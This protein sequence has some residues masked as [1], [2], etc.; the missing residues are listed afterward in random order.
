MHHFAV[1]LDVTRVGDAVVDPECW[2]RLGVGQIAAD[3]EAASKISH[4]VAVAM[5]SVDGQMMLGAEDMI[6]D[7]R[8]QFLA[9]GS[10]TIERQPYRPQSAIRS[11]CRARVQRHRV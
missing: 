3:S 11:S 8:I 4:A 1:D 5:I 7:G 2:G 10:I 9:A 6:E